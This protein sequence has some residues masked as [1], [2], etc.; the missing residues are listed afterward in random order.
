MHIGM[1]GLGPGPEHEDRIIR[2]IENDGWNR[3]ENPPDWVL[4]EARNERLDVK[5]PVGSKLELEGTAKRFLAIPAV[6]TGDIHVFSKPL[7]E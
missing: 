3:V 1:D 7:E 2:A 6:K 4:T 5:G